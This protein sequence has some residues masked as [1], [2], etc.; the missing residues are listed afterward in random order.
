M[1]TKDKKPSTVNGFTQSKFI[2]YSLTD[3]QKKEIKAWSPTQ[4]ELDDLLNTLVEGDYKV[5]F[6]Y[7][8]YNE[9]H[10]CAI[11]PKGEKHVNTGYI[12]TGKGSTPFKAL[13]QVSW[14]HF[15][16]LDGAWFEHF[17]ARGREILDD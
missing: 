14:I 12:L 1:A 8:D 17:T 5:T 13:K 15:K 3:A 11:V 2:N 9:C 16:V 10:S 4:E 6:S 7:D